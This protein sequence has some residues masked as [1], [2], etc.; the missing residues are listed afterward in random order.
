VKVVELPQ[1]QTDFRMDISDLPEGI[2]EA[3]VMTEDRIIGREKMV[4][5]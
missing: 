3:Q 2:Y 4:V 5:K 1:G